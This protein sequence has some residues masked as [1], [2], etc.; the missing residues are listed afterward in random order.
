MCVANR[1]E[2][3]NRCALTSW[4]EVG[5]SGTAFTGHWLEGSESVVDVDRIGC[6]G[7]QRQQKETPPL[8]LTSPAQERGKT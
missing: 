1:P 7:P 4:G 5:P 6:R 3:E 2:V 8:K